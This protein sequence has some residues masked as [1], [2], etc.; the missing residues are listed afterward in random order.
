MRG[1]A[2]LSQDGLVDLGWIWTG[3]LRPL[4]IEIGLLASYRFDESDWIAIEHGLAMTDS[5]AGPWF[6]YPVGH[7]LVSAALEP[8]ASEVA[9]IRVDEATDTEL[10]K[11]RWLGDLMRNWHLSGPS[12]G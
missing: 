9:F 11:I 1:S 6:D 8:G 4:L 2:D 5:E 3:N 7:I 12:A 10:E